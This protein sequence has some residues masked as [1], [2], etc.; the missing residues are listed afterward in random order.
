MVT[1]FVFSGGGSLG[2][3]QVGSLQ[4]LSARG[5]HPDIL[6]GTSAGSMNAAFVAGRGDDLGSLEELAAIWVEMRR[7]D[8][9]RTSAL[10]AALAALG[11][12]SALC[13]AASLSR[14]L[15][16][17]LGFSRLEEALLPLYVVTTDFLTGQGVLL[18]SGDVRQALL[19]SCAIPG[20]FPPVPREGRLLIDGALASDSGIAQAV[21]LGADRVYLLTGGTSCALAR[22]PQHPVAAALHGVTLLLQQRALLEARAYAHDVDLRV[23]PPLCP[24]SVS[25][26]DFGQAQLL[27]ARASRATGEWVDSGADRLPEPERF[28][29]LHDHT[30]DARQAARTKSA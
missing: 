18:S 13:S 6:V 14:L 15:R 3:V 5:I 19:A 10:G 20:M 21:E 11:R 29:R 1:A 27:I 26:A 12:R 9:F 24:L 30:R 17:R 23:I 4:A 7:R 28:L 16:E 8:V 2:A 22:A 25:A